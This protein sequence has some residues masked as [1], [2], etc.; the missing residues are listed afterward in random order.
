MRVLALIGLGLAVG[1]IDPEL[2]ACGDERACPV[3]TTCATLTVNGTP[4][5]VDAP[6]LAACASASAFDACPDGLCFESSV[7]L[8]CASSQCGDGIVVPTEMCDDG[9]T[10]SGDGCS[11]S[12]ASRETCGNGIIDIANGEQCDDGDTTGHD[13]CAADCR[14][15]SPSWQQLVTGMPE[16]LFGSGIVYDSARD[17]IV[18]FG[19]F[20]QFTSA[21][22]IP[23]PRNDVYEWDGA[24][25]VKVPAAIAPSRRTGTLAYDP[26]RRRTLLFGGAPN[27]TSFI[28][29]TWEWDG[30]SWTLLDVNPH[31]SARVD[32][33]AV[34]DSA[35]QRI[36]LFGGVGPGDTYLNETWEWDGAAWMQKTPGAAPAPRRGHAM[37]YDPVRGVIVM[38][39]GVNTSGVTADTWEYDGNVWRNTNAPT[40]TDLRGAAMAYDGIGMVTFGGATSATTEAKTYRYA[41]GAWQMLLDGSTGPLHRAYAAV[42]RDPV[43]GRVIMYGGYALAA[44]ITA[45]RGDMW[46]WNGSAWSELLVSVPPARALHASALDTYRGRLVVFGGVDGI[47]SSNTFPDT[48]ELVG[49]HWEQGGAGPS[50][51]ASPAM[52]YDSARRETILFGGR[53]NSTTYADTWRWNGTWTPLSPGMSPPE[54]AGHGLA[55]DPE[56]DVIVLFG[57]RNTQ[58]LADAWEW[59]GTTWR[60]V[61]PANGP[62]ARSVVHMAYDPIRK[63]IVLYG[64]EEPNATYNDTWAWNGSSWQAIDPPIAPP[65]RGLAGFAYNPARTTLTLFAGSSKLFTLLEDTWEL[66]GGS[67]AQQPIPT[68]P[69]RQG[70]S[71]ESALDGSGV[72]AFGGTQN[73]LATN[74]LWSLR[75]QTSGRYEL[76]SLVVDEDGDG[77][78]GCADPDCAARCMTCGNSV[79]DPRETCRSCPGDCTCAAVCG[80][81]FCDPGETAST[82]KGDCP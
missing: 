57:G 31:P 9:N 17:R 27:T 78:A 53:N 70:H 14:I 61:T 72:V 40:P 79:C 32:A 26:V 3:G 58:D 24:G 51:R 4:L 66:R 19:G 71:L 81:N 59:N 10:D 23:V 33:R 22:S 75:W 60:D 44:G 64:G 6:T 7:G 38:A 2:V 45:T 52:A 69:S 34:F 41:N 47:L 82:C 48:W 80:D 65:G 35:R 18:M 13:G 12:C 5:C 54:R 15:E 8:V 42:V 46:E 76:C 36:V 29:D 67:W 37:A 1:C 63:M 56:R 77:L 39:G 30:T 73:T 16:P 28:A 74:D 11:A 21:T 62:P 55:Y 20:Y 68:P 49:G 25:W 43:R 50:M